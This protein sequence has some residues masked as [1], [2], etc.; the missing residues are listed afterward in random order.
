[1][2]ENYRNVVVFYNGSDPATGPD[3]AAKANRIDNSTT[4]VTTVN[5]DSFSEILAYLAAH[6]RDGEIPVDGILKI[7]HAYGEPA[8]GIGQEVGNRGVGPTEIATLETYIK[9]N[10]TIILN[11]SSAESEWSFC[12]GWPSCKVLVTN[13]LRNSTRTGHGRQYLYHACGSQD[14][15]EAMSVW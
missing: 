2:I 14:A 6:T 7:D 9:Q 3:F 4:G 10:G 8:N 15:F 12:K 11:R 1:M 5:V 13:I